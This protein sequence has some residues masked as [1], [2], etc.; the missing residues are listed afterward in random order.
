MKQKGFIFTIDA[1]AAVTI[2]IALAI[3]WATFARAKMS[4][5]SY[6][7]SMEKIARDETVVALYENVLSNDIGA[8]HGE[9]FYVCSKYFKL[10]PNNDTTPTSVDVYQKCFN[11]T[12]VS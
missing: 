2:I 5:R 12:M 10:E 6:Y 11:S 3:V 4:E 9:K 1:L 8:M 7:E